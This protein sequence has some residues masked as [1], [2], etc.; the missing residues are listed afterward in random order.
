M[1]E[2]PRDPPTD[3]EAIAR[4]KQSATERLL[5]I[6]NVASVGIGPKVVGGEAS[7][8]PA[9][10]VF[11]RHKLPADQVPAGELIPPTIEAL[12]TDVEIGGDPVPLADPAP[13][14]RPGE[15]YL[16]R[17]DQ[18]T[19]RPVVGGARI[20]T[21]GSSAPGTLGCLMWDTSNHDVGYGLTCMHVVDALDIVEVIKDKTQ[22]GQP[23]GSDFSKGCCNDVIGVWAGGGQVARDEALVRLSSG[24]KW[25][26]QIT[27][28]GLVAGKHP[29]SETDVIDGYPY[30]VAKR[31]A[32]TGLTGGYLL[33][34]R[35]TTRELD[36]LIIIKPNP[37]SDAGPGD[38]V[39]FAY[40]GDS[41]S[42][43][44]NSANEVV[45][46]VARRDEHGFGYAYHIDAVLSRLNDIDKIAVDVASS[47]DLNE[48]HTVPGGTSVAV[49]VEVA[50]RVAADP[51]D[52]LAFTGANGRA[53]LGRPW[54]SDLPPTA[55]IMGRVRADLAASG[56][57]RL[58][59]EFW[60]T[61]HG[62]LTDLIERD[63]HV[64][65]IWHRGGG[66]ALTQLLLRLPAD[67]SR[68]LPAT[69]Y[70]EPLMRSVDRL[71]TVV[72]RS[73]SE[74]LRTDLDRVRAV[75]PDLAGLTYA[76][77]VAALGATELVLD[78]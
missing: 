7:G 58:L 44:V 8:E 46:L 29:L 42:A 63:R 69:L 62:E 61:H 40:E 12:K 41:G 66:A 14:D 73:A 5:A 39:F 53:P 11:V 19:Y 67:R 2:T 26:T 52:A 3:S 49:P 76:E 56:S 68:A 24:M 65:I 13:V 36:D 38:V 37:N 72:A 43:L 28:I 59:L 60:Q 55:T 16:A 31:G 71:H 18:T 75:M 21:V 45:G 4:V 10:K 78:D 47:T 17:F 20:V 27:E 9:I 77:I 64:T 32:H 51:V 25:K 50:E 57:G 35:V 6:P 15:I 54:F 74:H 30:K 48:I 33:A 34:H 70:G 22:I 1:A 23:T